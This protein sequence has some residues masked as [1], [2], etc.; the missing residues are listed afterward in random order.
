MPPGIE[1]TNEDIAYAEAV[2]LPEG[3]VFDEERRSFLRDFETLDLQA[4]PGSGKT[5]V[6]LAKL[7]I[8]ERKLPF[9]DGSGILVISHTN[10]AIDEIKDRLQSHCPNLFSYPNFVGTIQSFVDE[11]LAIPCYVQQYKDRPARI[12]SEIYDEIIKRTYGNMP[13]SAAKAWLANQ[14]EPEKVFA[15]LRFDD[16]LNLRK[17]MNGEIALRSDSNS[18]AYKVIKTIKTG[19]FKSG[20]LHYDDAYLFAQLYIKKFPLIIQILQKR[21]PHVFIDEMQ[22]MDTHQYDLIEKIF[23]SHA[24]DF[25]RVQR[26]GDKNQAIYNSV[27]SNSIWED[28]AKVLKLTGSQ[29]LSAPT[30]NVTKKF[31]LYAGGDFT[32]DGL[33]PAAIK[34][35]ML[36]YK[37]TTVTSVIPYYAQLVSQFKDNGQLID[38]EKYP[39]KAVAWNTEWKE[40]TEASKVRLSAFHNTYSREERN[41]KVDFI[42]LKSYLVNYDKSK[43]TLEP[44]RKNILNAILRVLRM[45]DVDHEGRAFTKKRLLQYLRHLNYV[46]Y[47]K[48]ISHLYKWSIE[49]VRGNIENVCNEMRGYIPDLLQLF[50]NNGLVKSIEFVNSNEIEN[51]TLLPADAKRA[52]NIYQA[53]NFNIEIESVHSVKGQ[54]HCATL[55]IESFYSQGYGHYESE[56]LRNQFL[57]SQT[58]QETLA[59]IRTSHDLVIQSAKMAY[60]GCSRPT[61]LLCVAIHK[62]RFDTHLSATDRNDWEVIE[63]PQMNPA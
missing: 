22:D 10:A 55:Y 56:R 16:N 38:F 23:C 24:N 27:R 14:H 18:P 48:L 41:T 61:N 35:H 36:L 21:F 4:V 7:L 19:I 30:A 37:D 28:R 52:G 1:I 49:V 6:L 29:R 17:G 2:L 58:I 3:K 20:I 63:V 44:I 5:T 34:P 45:E 25:P 8:L 42:N 51:I 43:T 50:N 53:D 46:E 62:D 57:G 54:T 31:A 59:S 13:N 39:I 33:N 9:L 40:P 11:F 26:I 15:N 47:E 32:I 12:D 60:V